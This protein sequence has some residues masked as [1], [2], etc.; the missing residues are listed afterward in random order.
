MPPRRQRPRESPAL[1][2]FGRQMRRL[3]EAKDIK[4]ETIAHL[5]KVS[6]PQ[7]SRIENGKK[8]ATRSFVIAVDDYLEAGG[9]LISLWEDLNK[10][11][12]PVPIWFDWPQVES[13][14]VMLVSWENSVVPGL[15]QTSAYASAMLRGNQEATDARI[16]RQTVLTKDDD[17]PSPTVLFLLDEHVLYNLVGTPETMREQLEHLLE[18]SLFPNITI[19]VVLGSG[20]HEGVLGS[21]VVAT[22]EDRSEVAYIETAVRGITTDNPADL[23][24]L[25]RTLVELRSRALTQ[26]MSRELIRKVIQEQWT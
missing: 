19:Q 15:A 12:H 13:D 25:A 16:S 24:I 2:A 6:G 8:R 7:V 10:D 1:V 5:T 9:S 22:M 21:F 26:A 23:S 17:S 4:Q 18:L 20:E 11:G 3:R 14:A